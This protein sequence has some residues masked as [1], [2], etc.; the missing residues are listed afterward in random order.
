[1]GKGYEQMLYK[2][3]HTL[4]L[5]GTKKVKAGG[6]ARPGRTRGG[7]SWA[8]ADNARRTQAAPPQARRPPLPVL[9]P[10]PRRAREAAASA[11]WYSGRRKAAKRLLG[12]ARLLLR[13]AA[14]RWRF[15]R[16]TEGE[17]DAVFLPTLTAGWRK[18]LCR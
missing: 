11:L 8:G 10:V 15:E 18:L 5:K 1:M 12:R 7:G 13:E 14:A 3:R 17:S 16:E 4:Y 2:R 9:G 6:P